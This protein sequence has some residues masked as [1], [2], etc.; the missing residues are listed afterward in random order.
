MIS[1]PIR[2]RTASISDLHGIATQ[3]RVPAQAGDC[4]DHLRPA[5]RAEA[6]RLDQALNR[7]RTVQRITDQE[8]A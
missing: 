1:V 7:V 5:L 2:P 4:P 8:G 6:D 3:L